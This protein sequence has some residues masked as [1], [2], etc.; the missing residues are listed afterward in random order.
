M[1]KPLIRLALPK[2]SL[3]ES[4]FKLMKRA[5]FEI[6]LGKRAYIPTIDDEEMELRL[7]RAQEIP[8]YVASGALDAGITGRD[9][10]EEACVKVKE[11]GELVYAKQGL[12]RI[13]W[14]LAV[15]QG[16]S[17]KS[18]KDLQGKTVA[19]EVV[20]ITRN[21]LKKHQVKANVEFSW[22]A[23]EVKPPELCDAIVELTETGRSLR[24]NQLKVIDVVLESATRVIMNYS[25]YRNKKKRE[26][27][28]NLYLLLKGA[29]EAEDKIGLKMNAPK[30]KIQKIIQVLPALRKP[31]VSPL[32]DQKYVALEVV[33]G[34]KETRKL[35]PELK[36]LGAEGIIAFSLEKVIY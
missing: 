25:S 26:K 7:I 33:V 10:I 4:T 23:T 1:S 31:T 15:P 6:S 36:R 14:V 29:L 32:S 5:G 3:Q 21:F 27:I 18:V 30:S 17:I 19:T 28:E 9:W 16:S 24:A 12:G 8:R 2:G 34:K 20:N 13:K 22:G 35:I 11:M